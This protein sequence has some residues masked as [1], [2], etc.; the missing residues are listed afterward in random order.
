M[1]NVTDYRDRAAS[2]RASR[3]MIVRACSG[4]TGSQTQSQCSATRSPTPVRRSARLPS[5]DHRAAPRRARVPAG[6]APSQTS[7]RERTSTCSPSTA[8]TSPT[9]IRHRSSTGTAGPGGRP[10][11][12]HPGPRV[13]LEHLEA[14]VRGGPRAG[15]SRQVPPSCPRNRSRSRSTSARRVDRV[16]QVVADPVRLDHPLVERVVDPRPTRARNSR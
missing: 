15:A 13:D 9:R 10:A 3:S 2:V 8:R 16:E 6:R 7:G 14:V 5:T 1:Q 12:Q 4:V 11:S